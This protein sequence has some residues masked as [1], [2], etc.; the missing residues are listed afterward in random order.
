VGLGDRAGALPA[1]LSGGERQR[2]ALCAA[3]AHRPALLLADEPTGELD[4]DSAEAV[5]ELL[6]T[7]ARVQG[8]SVVVVSHDPATAE[9]ADRAVR[10]RDGRVSEERRGGAATL[11]VG[12]GGWLQVPES[13]LAEAGIEGRVT[14]R[15]HD[16]GVL[17]ETA[18]ER[19]APREADAPEPAPT[20][21]NGSDPF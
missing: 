7:L 5:N 16:G 18:G 4:A 8:A 2:V 15:A 12:R 1:E 6:S 14:A 19:A 20:L 3:L 13:L 10:L 21:P 11:V 17:L 9:I